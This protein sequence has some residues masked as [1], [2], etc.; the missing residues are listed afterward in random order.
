MSVGYN[1]QLQVNAYW[2]SKQEQLQWDNQVQSL[3]LLLV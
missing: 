3:L 1:T 2:E